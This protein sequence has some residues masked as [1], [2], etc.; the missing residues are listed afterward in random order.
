MSTTLTLNLIPLYP[1]R[2]HHGFYRNLSSFQFWCGLAIK[3]VLERSALCSHKIIFNL[4]LSSA[5]PQQSRAAC[6]Q[7]PPPQ[8]W[9]QAIH[10]WQQITLALL[11]TL[12]SKWSITFPSLLLLIHLP[13]LPMLTCLPSPPPCL[14]T[15]FLPFPT[16][17]LP[18]PPPRPCLLTFSFERCLSPNNSASAIRFGSDEKLRTTSI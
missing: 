5:D 3:M 9:C 14:L 7:P 2:E 4:L 15:V 18:P 8:K 13:L 17:H 16:A 11:P 12:P 6:K 10:R 1:H